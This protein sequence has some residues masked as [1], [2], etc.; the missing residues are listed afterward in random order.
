MSVQNCET[1]EVW[2]S[3]WGFFITQQTKSKAPFPPP[4]GESVLISERS[5]G[6]DAPLLPYVRS[7]AADLITGSPLPSCCR[8]RVTSKCFRPCFS[9]YPPQS[10]R[11][12]LVQSNEQRTPLAPDQNP[13]LPQRETPPPLVVDLF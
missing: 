3:L 12:F 6:A 11:S 7:E 5:W 4:R 13:T 2:V 9:S 10:S 8:C 1:S